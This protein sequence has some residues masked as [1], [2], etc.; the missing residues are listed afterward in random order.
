[1]VDGFPW[2]SLPRFSARAPALTRWLAGL[3]TRLGRVDQ[4]VELRRMGLR[5]RVAMMDLVDGARL[6]RRMADPTA[7]AL[8]LARADGAG[9]FA[10]L[11]GQLIRALA[12]P[13][14]AM[15]PHELAAPRAPTM[16]ERGVAAYLAAGVLEELGVEGVSVEL[17]D[18]VAPVLPRLI[19][20]PPHLLVD[21]A[22]SGRAP[23]RGPEVA[24]RIALVGNPAALGPAPLRPLRDERAAWLERAPMQ[25]PLAV[26]RAWLPSDALAAVQPRDVIVLDARSNPGDS[27]WPAPAD[28]LLLAGRGA[29]RVTGLAPGQSRITVAGT[30]A[31]SEPMNE[32]LAD[33]VTVEVAVAAGAVSLSARQVLELAPGQVL[34]LGRPLGGPVELLVGRRIIGRGELVDVDGELGV[35]ILAVET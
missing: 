14:L 9:L 35:R 25:L 6:E 32:L 31:R 13:L 2:Q 30:Y 20:P 11:E 4:G 28:G 27:A 22:V 24:G 15:P 19:G 1:V 33:D 12:A 29:L 26:G 10:V 3:G 7:V 5:G 21:I 16:A 18:E 8:W 34:A 23:G 17:S